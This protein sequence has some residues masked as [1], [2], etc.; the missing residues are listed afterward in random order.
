MDV[1][2]LYDIRGKWGD[3]LTEDKVFKIGLAFGEF[4]KDTDYIGVVRDVRI[5]SKRIRDILIDAITRT[6]N[7]IDF[8]IGSTPEAAY[9]ARVYT[10]PVLMIT[11]SH[12][13]KEYNGIKVIDDKGY[14]LPPEDL[15]AIE[16]IYKNV[17][18]FEGREGIVEEDTYA[19]EIYKW[20]LR[21]KFRNIRGYKIGYD[22]SNSVMSIF[23][24]VFQDL[25]NEVFSINSELDGNFPSHLPDPAKDENMQQMV[26]L[27]KV[28]GLDFGVVFDGDG[29]RLGV[30]DNNGRIIRPYEYLM[31]F[32][33]RGRKFL[34][35]VS[36]P[37][38]L[39]EILKRDG[40]EYVIS[41]T[42]R[43]FIVEK[44]I[45]NKVFLAVES[46]GHYYFSN[47][48]YSSDS[49]YAIL[50]LIKELRDKGIWFDSLKLE[51]FNRKEIVI[52]KEKGNLIEK[53]KDYFENR[54]V[55]I[56]NLNGEL[57]GID[58]LGKGFRIL[59]RESQTEPI[60]RLI[61]EDYGSNI[62]EEIE[63]ILSQL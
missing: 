33:G 60:Y 22:P 16:N 24:D 57:D 46:S 30:V 15:K 18:N 43:P 20:Y 28:K 8:G 21:K 58:I 62:S 50:M 55:S 23:I 48:F 63:K 44:S 35:E 12:N 11:A 3:E 59:V 38:I 26:D 56:D 6:H 54:D 53:I 51:E 42:G 45:K 41:R 32:L 29:D 39:R 40:Y 19:V 9:L 17:R 25:G 31:A 13:P 2:K 4:F 36:L 49:L 34:L 5:H 14:E 7:V 61:V 10:I 1:F 27:V 47:N 52:K 37:Y